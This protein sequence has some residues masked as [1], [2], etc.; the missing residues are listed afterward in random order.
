MDF[1]VIGDQDTVVG[2]RFAGVHGVIVDNAREAR[3]ELQR[4]CDEQPQS[5]VVITER[6]ANQ[7]RDAID[8]IRFG[9]RLPLLVEIPGPRGPSEETPSLLSL[10]REAVGIKV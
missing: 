8:D 9:E 7:I 5:I 2:F 3:E 10:I 6:I 1:Y 4:V